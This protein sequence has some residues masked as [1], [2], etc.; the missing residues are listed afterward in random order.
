MIGLVCAALITVIAYFWQGSWLLGMIIGIS[1]FC[2]LVIGTLTRT[3]IPLVLS[4]FKV[5]PAVASGPL[6]T[7]LND[8]LS[9][10]IYFGIATRFLG[11][12]M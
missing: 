3:C 4:R 12:L 1:L 11:A 6:I 8:I 2:T 10:F 7:T 5:D 9:L